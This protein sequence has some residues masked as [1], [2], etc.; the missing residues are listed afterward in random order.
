MKRTLIRISSAALVACLVLW[1]AGNAQ[2]A[3][4]YRMRSA[5][6]VET[7]SKRWIDAG[8]GFVG[9]YVTSSIIN[10]AVRSTY[11]YRRPAIVPIYSSPVASVAPA[12]V[13]SYAD[14]FSECNWVINAAGAYQQICPYSF[15]ASSIAPTAPVAFASPVAV[16]QQVR[17]YSLSNAQPVTSYR[18]NSTGLVGGTSDAL[19]NFFFGN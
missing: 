12:A 15:P 2:A 11:S 18:G 1:S 14:G 13:P 17:T 7:S 10:D 16:E 8:V 3:R 4:R 19:A 9:G 5:R 6:S